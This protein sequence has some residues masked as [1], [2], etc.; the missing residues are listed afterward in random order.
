VSRSC[1]HCPKPAVV[2]E[3]V[4]K[5]GI[6]AEVHLCEDHAAEH[7]YGVPAIVAPVGV[8]PVLAA[9]VTLPAKSVPTRT[10]GSCGLTL[11]QIRQ[12]GTL[13]CPDCYAHF[14]RELRH[15]IERAQA[16]AA[17]HVGRGPGRSD[18]GESHAALRMKLVRELEEAVR[19]EQYER[20]IRIRDRLHEL[21]GAVREA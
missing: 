6:A 17:A 13:G 8:T 19:S 7:G 15:V 1:D 5:G 18:P 2:H 9:L 14:E 20:A 4:I 10:C 12:Q 16:G 11:G 3:T 21:S